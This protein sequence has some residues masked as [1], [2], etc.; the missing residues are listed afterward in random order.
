MDHH[1]L[2]RLPCGRISLNNNLFFFLNFHLLIGL[3]GI[4]YLNGLVK[5]VRAWEVDCARICD[6]ATRD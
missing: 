1:L 2:S 6:F 4:Q 5:S 3:K